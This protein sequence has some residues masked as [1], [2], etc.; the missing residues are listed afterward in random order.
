MGPTYYGFGSSIA[1]PVLDGLA[2]AQ[3]FGLASGLRRLTAQVE[4]G[5]IFPLSACEHR[6]LA[7][8]LAERVAMKRLDRGLILTAALGLL[9]GTV[10]QAR[11]GISFVDMFRN[12]T[13]VQTGNGN[14]ITPT[15]AFFSADLTS[16]GAND[17]NAVQLTYP[18]PGSPVSLPQTSPT[19]FHFQT[20]SFAN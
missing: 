3:L 15:G 17:F 18:G 1:P 9:L 7:G 20:A 16:T 12:D 4:V 2:R 11:A 13:F 5:S 19:L 14:M 10:G 8:F 6:S